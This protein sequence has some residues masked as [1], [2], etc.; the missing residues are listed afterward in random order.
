LNLAIR[1]IDAKIEHGES[2]HADAHKD[3]KADYVIANP[4]DQ[5]QLFLPVGDNNFCRRSPGC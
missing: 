3:L 4:P 1:G 5:R 2:F